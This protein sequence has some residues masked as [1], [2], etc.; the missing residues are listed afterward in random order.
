MLENWFCHGVSQWFLFY[1]VPHI[2]LLCIFSD[3][4]ILKLFS[5]QVH[6]FS[7]F[8]F[9]GNPYT[10][11]SSLLPRR[12][13]QIS[14]PRLAF[15]FLL[16]SSLSPGLLTKSPLPFS[17]YHPFSFFITYLLQDSLKVMPFGLVV[18]TEVLRSYEIK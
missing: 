17:P 6:P 15:L 9:V 18:C 7:R 13:Q 12:H 8:C 4:L 10:C 1:F 11:L 2:I 5:L 16:V 14:L 3:F